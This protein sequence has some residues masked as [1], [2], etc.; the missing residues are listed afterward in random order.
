MYRNFESRQYF[1]LHLLFNTL[2]STFRQTLVL[3]NSH[4]DCFVKKRQGQCDQLHDEYYCK[5]E[6]PKV[7]RICYQYPYM[8]KLIKKILQ[9]QK[10]IIVNK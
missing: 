10:C 8:A 7:T 3:T 5:R 4:R 1:Y 2:F 6:R 9:L